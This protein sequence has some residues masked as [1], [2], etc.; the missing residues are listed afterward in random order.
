MWEVN[1]RRPFRILIDATSGTF[2]DN[3]AQCPGNWLKATDS[4][5]FACFYFAIISLMMF[6]VRS[7]STNSAYSY[8][9][10]LKTYQI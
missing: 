6:Y 9:F 2:T 7:P 10:F 3:R 1:K 5:V 8:E 4:L